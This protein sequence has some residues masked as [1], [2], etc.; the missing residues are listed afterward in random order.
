[1]NYERA[2]WG[3]HSLD[4]ES[5]RLSGVMT[6]DRTEI[7]VFTVPFLPAISTI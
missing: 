4:S 1:M 5:G 2:G 6:F 3:E 7:C